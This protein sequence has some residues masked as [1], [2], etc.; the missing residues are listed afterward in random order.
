VVDYFAG[1]GGFTLGATRAGARVVAA[2]NHWPVAVQTHAANH[3]E[4]LHA[5]E[6]LTRFD[7][8]R[9]P[10]FDI[11]VASPACQGHARARG[12]A[13]GSA[14]DARWDDSRATA[15]A[16]VDCLE[17]R[18]PRGVVVENVLDFARWQLFPV[19]LDALS[20][21]G[22]A[23]RV[24]VCDAAA[25]GVAQERPRIIVTA[26]HG[27]EAPAVT[28]PS[29]PLRPIG[30]VIRWDEGQWTPV[31]EKVAATRAR[32]ANGRARFGARFVMPYNGS[33]SGLT[34]RSLARPIGTI[35]KRAEGATVA[36]TDSA[37]GKAERV[38]ALTAEGSPCA[39]LGELARLRLKAAPKVRANKRR[40]AGRG[41]MDGSSSRTRGLI[42]RSGRRLA[43]AGCAGCR[44][45]YLR[46]HPAL[47]SGA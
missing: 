1:L 25:W 15:W 36:V 37:T 32:V 11:L 44:Q 20:R 39:W 16:V 41:D 46:C 27:R 23:P 45:C 21:L 13:Q 38:L 4:V 18:R 19:W 6:D 3:P 26:E 43:S 2:I 34:G 10:A 28:A 5:C 24:Q 7:P 47:P 22:Y 40:E 30:D 33:G 14:G 9:L 29:L 17:V 12:V 42:L 31:A 35:T 8:R